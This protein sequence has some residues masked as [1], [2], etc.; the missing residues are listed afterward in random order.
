MSDIVDH[1]ASNLTVFKLSEFISHEKHFIV[2]MEYDRVVNWKNL[3]QY[4]CSVCESYSI[5]HKKKFIKDSNVIDWDSIAS[6]ITRMHMEMDTRQAQYDLHAR[7]NKEVSDELASP[8]V[9]NVTIVEKGFIIRAKI[10]EYRRNA[11]YIN[12]LHCQD[13]LYYG[14]I[15]LVKNG[16]CATKSILKEELEELNAYMKD[17]LKIEYKKSKSVKKYAKHLLKHIP[18]MKKL[19]KE[20]K[21]RIRGLPLASSVQPV[22]RKDMKCVVKIVKL[23][24]K[25]TKNGDRQ[26]WLKEE[27]TESEFVTRFTTPLMDLILK[28]CSTK[29]IFKP[30]DQKLQIVK[31]Y[32]NSALT[33][34]KTRLPGP[35]IDG[36]IKNIDLDIPIYLV[37]VSGSPNSPA[38][39]YSHYKGD[40]NKLA[41]NLKY[42]LKIIMS[43]KGVPSFESS[44]KIKL[45]GIHLYSDQVYVYSLSMPIWDVFVFN[46]E[47][48]FDIPVKPT[49]FPSTLPTFISKLFQVGEL[50]DNFSNKL[51]TFL[52]A[53]DYESSS[54]SDSDKSTLSNPKVSPKKRKHHQDN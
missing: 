8:F 6:Q 10:D 48:K 15:D 21:E 33:E 17:H 39:N 22:D 14:V 23:F 30:G 46:L 49:L 2:K 24:V 9:Q 45:F 28:R 3:K 40:R 38:E 53:N 51:E 37:E 54:S 13:L 27:M 32:E 7:I 16:D 34:D 25:V 50:L 26:N 29:M 43:M 42:V 31:D 44:S 11:N 35:N 19:A 12:E 18:D 4:W 47:F 52:S 20:E 41:K 1:Y 5:T 36:I